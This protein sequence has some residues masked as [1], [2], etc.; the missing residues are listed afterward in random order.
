MGDSNDWPERMIFSKWSNK[1]SVR[2]QTHRLDHTGKLYDMIVD[3]G[4]DQDISQRMPKLA[5]QLR[6]AVTDWKA[7]M[8]GE[9]TKEHRP[10]T[11]GFVSAPETQLPAR[12]GDSSG[13]VARSGRAPNCSFFTNWSSTE[14]RIWWDVDILE[15][16][17]YE[18]FM[19]STCSAKN[20]G[21]TFELKIGDE[22]L[23]ATVTKAHDPPLRGAEADR[24]NRGSESYVKDFKEW[25][26][27]QLKLTK[28]RGKLSL[29]AIEI[30]GDA[31]VDIRM[32]IFRKLK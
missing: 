24:A 26:L 1:V 16:G 17:T 30:L 29:K 8:A 11:V 7:E 23:T 10:L 5:K 14:D 28:K 9:T 3:P 25:K 18:V 20:V 19:M 12:D 21:A 4:Q 31:V 27:G 2:T 13:N 32:L 6:Q 22:S 15:S